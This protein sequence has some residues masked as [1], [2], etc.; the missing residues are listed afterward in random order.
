MD[1]VVNG[2]FA[3]DKERNKK[4]RVNDDGNPKKQYYLKKRCVCSSTMA[5][6]ERTN[7]L[8]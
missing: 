5:H 4:A 2:C 3:I 8:R 6:D 1:K 7:L